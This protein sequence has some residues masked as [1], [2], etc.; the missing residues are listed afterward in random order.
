VSQ[1]TRVVWRVATGLLALCAI[2]LLVTYA[3]L[4][5]VRATGPAPRRTATPDTE[6]AVA[7]PGPTG[8]S[9]EESRPTLILNSD[10][11]SPGQTIRVT[12]GGFAPGASIA[13]R[14]GVPNAGLSK[15]N[16]ATAVAD[17]HGAFELKLTVPT[18]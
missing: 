17:A 2:G 1:R 7:T 4:G 16:L 8:K 5:P 13:L 15:A 6:S 9:A 3:A 12:G 14:L 11:G 18:A 10:A